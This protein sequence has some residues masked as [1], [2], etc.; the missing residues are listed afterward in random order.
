MIESREI[1]DLLPPVAAMARNHAQ[2]FEQDGYRLLIY[3]TYRDE[4]MQT[5]LYARGR[6]RPGRVVTNARAGQSMHQW[7]VAYDAIPT[8]GGKAL[9]DD[10]DAVRLM[11]LA[12]EAAGLEWAGRWRGKLR[13]RV[14]FQA[15]QFKGWQRV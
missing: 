4:A 2:L 3:C 7:R 12:G 5:A 1:D 6:T 13:E 15:P 8:L 14:H 10:E 9:W 11:G